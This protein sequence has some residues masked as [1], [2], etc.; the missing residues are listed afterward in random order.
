L[1]FAVCECGAKI[2]VVPDLNE[3][4]S[5]IV[6]H[7]KAHAKKEMPLKKAKAERHRIEELLTQK[8]LKSINADET[9]FALSDIIQHNQKRVCF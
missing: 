4:A 6:I 7:A 8:V 1:I 5:S 9:K 2:L 3:M